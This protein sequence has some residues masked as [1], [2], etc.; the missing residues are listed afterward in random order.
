MWDS[1]FN[2]GGALGSS[3]P[4]LGTCSK[5]GSSDKCIAASLLLHLSRESSGY[6]ENIRAF[7]APNVND[8]A[9]SG[10]NQLSIYTG[11]GILI[12][13]QG[14]SWLLGTS[15]EHSTLY[16]YQ[17]FGAKDVYLGQVQTETPNSQSEV[18]APK[19]FVY[20]GWG[21][22]P[23]DP[24]FKNCPAKSYECRAAWGIRVIDSSN[25]LMHSAGLSSLNNTNR[26]DCMSRHNCQEALVEV[27]NSMNIS[28][29]NLFTVGIA[30]VATG[31]L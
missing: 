31:P 14:P 16:Q 6:F 21:P 4:D 7:T 1:H 11:R 19:P 8:M 13:S 2:V 27:T 30:Q 29:F 17:L 5:G 10:S 15:S 24:T 25:V 20:D 22:F 26:P 23:S 28:V 18:M 12:E 9:D 3:D